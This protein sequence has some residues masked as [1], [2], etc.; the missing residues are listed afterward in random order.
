MSGDREVPAA[1]R[2]GMPMDGTEARAADARAGT[3]GAAIEIFEREAAGAVAE[4]Y[5]SDGP[6]GEAAGR[7]LYGYACSCG[8][9]AGLAVRRERAGEMARLHLLEA[10]APGGAS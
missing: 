6:E 3:G 5:V 7:V 8:G 10:H 4:V 9:S 1:A 2:K